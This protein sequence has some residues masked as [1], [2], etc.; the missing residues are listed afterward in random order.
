MELA[1]VVMAV[2]I[3]ISLRLLEN[4]RIHLSVPA[5]F[6]FLVPLELEVIVSAIEGLVVSFRLSEIFLIQSH[7]ETAVNLVSLFILGWILSQ[8][9]DLDYLGDR[10]FL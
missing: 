8:D 3:W 2:E 4:S 1:F 6:K 7:V 5:R 9:D 10:F